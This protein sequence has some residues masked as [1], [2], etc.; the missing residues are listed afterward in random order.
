M[1]EAVENEGSFKI[2]YFRLEVGKVI[3]ADRDGSHGKYIVI[4][5]P[6]GLQ[7]WYMHLSDIDVS[8]GDEVKKGASIGNLGSTG[9][10]TGPHLHFEIVKGGKAVDPMPYLK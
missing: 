4:E 7:T 6:G 9:R 10:S 2:A 1:E 3:T 8:V 5:H